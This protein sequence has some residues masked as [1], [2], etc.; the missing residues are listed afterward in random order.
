MEIDNLKIRLSPNTKGLPNLLK[1]N[2]D[3]KEK[4]L[5]IIQNVYFNGNEDLNKKKSI[6]SYPFITNDIEKNYDDD[7]DK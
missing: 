1:K 2:F 7:N 3:R 5:E 4:F 6:S